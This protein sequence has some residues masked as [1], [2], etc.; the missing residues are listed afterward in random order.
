MGHEVHL[1]RRRPSMMGMA[2]LVLAFTL[3]AWGV[4]GRASGA[5]GRVPANAAGRPNVLLVTVDSFRP[6]H[7]SAYGYPKPTTPTLDR[8]ARRG[9]LFRQAI[10]QT[11][12][13][14]PSLVSIL[15]AL[16]PSTHGVDGRTKSVNPSVIT[17]LK[18]LREAGY[19]VPALSYL[20][21]LPEF[22]HLGFEPS[23]EKE[24][25]P[26]LVKNSGRPFFAW[27]HLEGPHLPLNPRPPYDRMFTPGGRP[28]PADVLARLKPFRQNP[29]ITK[30]EVRVDPADYWAVTALYDGKVRRTDDE[31][32]QILGV[33]DR[34]GLSESTLVIISADHG[35]ELLDHGFIGHASTSLAGTLYD[36]VIRVPLIMVYPPFLPKGRS[37]APQVEGID[38]LPTVL[39]ML[40]IPPPPIMQGR[41][42]L[43]LIRGEGQRPPQRAFSETTTC[44]RSCPEGTEEGRLQSLRTPTWKLIRIQNPAGERFELYHLTS[45]PKE[46][47]NVAAKNPQTFSRLRAELHQ[48]LASS[49]VQAEELRALARLSTPQDRP[50]GSASSGRPRIV[51]PRDGWQLSHRDESGRVIIEWEGN[52]NS[53]YVLEYEV[54]TGKYHLRGDFTVLGLRKEFGPLK[55]EVWNLLPLY[56]PF[57][58][59]VRPAPCPTPSCWSQWVTFN[60]G[61]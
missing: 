34:L 32:A 8:L 61:A 18:R 40:A 30:G 39:E 15:T 23:E 3:P 21:A 17:P 52:P 47:R 31:I 50:G 25:E 36:E 41:S 29:V 46:R 19:S 4:T 55:T 16:Y 10:N 44:G 28:L 24:L 48:W 11:S 1:M 60:V 58:V 22:E 33:L 20:I 51:R 38:I 53:R 45:D 56:N 59:R 5:G 49:L 35:D 42:L 43:P 13:T 54:G 14:S 12:W 2:A 7:L 9:V 27:I 57:K 6:D 37:I 26:W